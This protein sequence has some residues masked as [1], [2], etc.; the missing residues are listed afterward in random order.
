MDKSFYRQ[1]AK[2]KEKSD[3]K[4]LIFRHSWRS[5]QLDGSLSTTQSGILA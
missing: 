5:L 2:G 1:D 4:S 3:G